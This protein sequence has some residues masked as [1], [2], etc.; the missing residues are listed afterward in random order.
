MYEIKSVRIFLSTNF[1]D[2]TMKG[3]EWW[4]HGGK[5]MWKRNMN[6]CGGGE[7]LLR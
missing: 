5:T 4:P 2:Q 3:S 1:C 7:G 6:K